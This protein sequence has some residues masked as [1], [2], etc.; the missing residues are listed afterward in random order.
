MPRVV[1]LQTGRARH[2]PAAVGAPR[3]W[4]SAIAKTAR[5]GAVP[6]GP[7]GFAEDEQA[8][9]KNHGG[10]HKAVLGY[11]AAHYPAWAAELAREFPAGGF[12]ENLTFADLD[13]GGVCI[14]DVWRLP[15]ALLEVSQPRQ[16]C[17]NPA[18]LWQVADL[19][20]RMRDSGRTGWYFRVAGVGRIAAGDE[21]TL[22][23]RP[24]PQWTVARVNDIF[25]RG[26][27][28]REAMRE[29]AAL[30]Q[31]APAWR[32]PFARRAGSV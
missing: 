20:Q 4:T 3:G 19:D 2:Y 16:P 6:L 27:E 28:Q 10:P 23:A 1:S 15:G 7:E 21:L 12:G 29:L 11:A 22:V 17:R 26:R 9:R 25:Y 5:A 30:P 14:G 24:W 8:D 32:E 31:L 18:L 13:E